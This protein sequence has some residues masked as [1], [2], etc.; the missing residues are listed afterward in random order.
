MDLDNILVF[1][2]NSLFPYPVGEFDN[3]KAVIS[4]NFF[5]VIAGFSKLTNE[6]VNEWQYGELNLYLTSVEE[7]SV[8]FL[9]F[10]LPGIKALFDINVHLLGLTDVDK[11]FILG[12][13]STLV[14][15]YLVENTN[16][17]LKAI[18]TLNLRKDLTQKIKEAW[19]K[20]AEMKMSAEEYNQIISKIESNYSTQELQ[21]LSIFSQKF[22]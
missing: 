17:Y 15:I 16:N 10:E 21:R 11:N 3:I 14:N 7:L 9:I 6:E 13:A 1:S 18:R 19:S 4:S 2:T 8:V 22:S 5:N 12:S 20:Q